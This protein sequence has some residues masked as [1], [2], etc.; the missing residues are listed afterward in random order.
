M[1]KFFSWFFFGEKNK[2]LFVLF[3]LGPKEPPEWWLDLESELQN[4]I[5]TELESSPTVRKTIM[6]LTQHF[7]LEKENTEESLRWQQGKTKA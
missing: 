7:K 4:E 6:A 3:F 2:L 5:M 1:L